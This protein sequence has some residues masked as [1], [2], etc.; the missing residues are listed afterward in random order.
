MWAHSDLMPGNL[1]VAEGRLAA[2]IDFGTMGV[3]DPACDLI[4][5]WNLLPDPARRVFRAAVGAGDATWERGRGWALSMALLQ[6][7][8][9]RHSNPTMAAN[10][11]HVLR[12]VLADHRRITSRSGRAEQR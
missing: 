12:E 5:A 9:Y 11:R 10:A 2:V 6:L 3:G 7:P 8:Y 1:L 4:P